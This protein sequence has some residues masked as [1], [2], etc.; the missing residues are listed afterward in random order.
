[1]AAD[2][3]RPVTALAD[4]DG[5]QHD[6]D[7]R[8]DGTLRIRQPAWARVVFAAFVPVWLW[9]W[10]TQQD[11]GHPAPLVWAVAAFAVAVGARMFVM[12]VDG[13]A[14]GRLVVRNQLWTRTFRREELADAVVDRGSRLGL[15]ASGWTVW[16]VLQDGSRHRVQLTEAPFRTGFAGRLERQAEEIR[17]WIV[18]DSRPAPYLPG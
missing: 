13:T 1:M 2:P 14:D 11:A 17:R 12:G 10:F 5:S 6:R 3:P 9:I 4:V 15:A 7:M 18:A 8:S 16:L